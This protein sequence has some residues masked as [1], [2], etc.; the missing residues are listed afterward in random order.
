MNNDALEQ[1]IQGIGMMTELHM[2]T[3]QNFLAQKMTDE[4]ALKHTKA[5][6]AV[7]LEVLM[8]SGGRSNE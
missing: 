7:M 8:K 1:F 2:I 4:E 6:M 3:Y 5:F